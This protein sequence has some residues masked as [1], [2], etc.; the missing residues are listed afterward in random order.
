MHGLHWHACIAAGAV[1]VAADLDVVNVG[2]AET[3]RL[4]VGAQP[5]LEPAPALAVVRRHAPLQPP[6]G[7][8]RRGCVSTLPTGRGGSN[9]EGREGG[10]GTCRPVI[11]SA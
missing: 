11:I 5:R 6:S 7:E 3:E 9:L 2:G 1:R 4:E 10:R 8:E